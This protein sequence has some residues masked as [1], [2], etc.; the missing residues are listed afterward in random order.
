MAALPL[1]VSF[2]GLD[3]RE[4]VLLRGPRG[5][6]EFAP[7]VEY[8]DTEAVSW[9]RAALETAWGSVP[10]PV[11]ERVAVN[12]TVP[13]V[14]ADR[15]API[16]DSFAGCRTAKIKVAQWGQ[17]LADDIARVSAARDHLG[18][19]AAIRVDANGGWDLVQ[20]R[21]AI[22]ALS[23]YHLEYAEQPVADVADLARLRVRLAAAGV[24]V[25]IAADESIRRAD[26]PLEV[27]RLE[28][29]DL[30]VV[31]VAPLGGVARALD[32]VSDCGLPA[33]VSSALDTSVGIS[34]GLALAC[35]LPDLSHACGLGTVALLGRDVA[36]QPLVPVRG[37]LSIEAARASLASVG[38]VAQ[39]DRAVPAR[40]AWWQA[41]LRRC[42]ALL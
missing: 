8:D 14:S 16:L 24:D 35:A 25:P 12:A 4:A 28:A 27:A 31:K 26:D 32:I 42:W 22:T 17:S 20:A 40:A 10:S 2:R 6:G 21:D 9:L 36:A 18:P 34:A 1:R 15:V 33:V 5:W 23:A 11:R 29:A 37:E 19:S 13:A 3:H 7:F 38:E 30:I 39:A 41:R